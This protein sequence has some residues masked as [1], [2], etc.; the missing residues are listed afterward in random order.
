MDNEE[1]IEQLEAKVDFLTTLVLKQQEVIIAMHEG[2]NHHIN[3][4]GDLKDQVEHIHNTSG[5]NF[6]CL[7]KLL[8]LSFIHKR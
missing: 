1:R 4:T 5:D 7:L 8:C 2:N 3:F 6:L